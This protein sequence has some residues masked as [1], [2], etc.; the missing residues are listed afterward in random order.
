MEG[1]QWFAEI[2]FHSGDERRAKILVFHSGKLEPLKEGKGSCLWRK[3]ETRSSCGGGVGIR[4]E[5]W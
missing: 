1:I 2:L 4:V 3:R 5:G